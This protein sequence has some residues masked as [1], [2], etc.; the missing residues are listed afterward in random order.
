MTNNELISLLTPSEKKTLENFIS[1]AT[2]NSISKTDFE[3]TAAD[4]VADLVADLGGEEVAD[5]GILKA[6]FKKYSLNE[7]DCDD[8][9]C[10]YGDNSEKYLPMENLSVYLDELDSQDAF[11]VGL[12]SK[13]FSASQDY[14]YWDDDGFLRSGTTVDIATLILESDNEFSEDF[15]T[16]FYE[17]C[18]ENLALKDILD[19]I[20]KLVSNQR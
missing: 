8:V 19:I 10:R 3:A 20:K 12:K 5:F 18:C 9:I 2:I 6:L 7:T 17:T 1:N 15:L 4:L 16:G 13:N 11:S 14:Y